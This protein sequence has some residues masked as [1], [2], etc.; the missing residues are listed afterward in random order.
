MLCCDNNCKCNIETSTAHFSRFSHHPPPF[1]R[2]AF[3][4][5][6][7]FHINTRFSGFP[8]PPHIRFPFVSEWVSGEKKKENWKEKC[9]FDWQQPSAICGIC[10]FYTIF[11]IYV[12]VDGELGAL[13]RPHFGMPSAVSRFPQ[14]VFSFFFPFFA[15]IFELGNRGDGKSIVFRLFFVFFLWVKGF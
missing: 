8:Q 2:S 1:S 3:G 5:W 6:S 15:L 14:N 7:L 13:T 12:C 9:N 11:F 10:V 4:F